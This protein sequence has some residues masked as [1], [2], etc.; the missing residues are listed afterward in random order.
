[1]RRWTFL[2]QPACSVVRMPSL[3]LRNEME[4]HRPRISSLPICFC[5]SHSGGFAISSPD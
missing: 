3:S 5:V 2:L 4:I 1:M